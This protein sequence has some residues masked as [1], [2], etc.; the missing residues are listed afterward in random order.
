[1]VAGEC[2]TSSAFWR[3]DSLRMADACCSGESLRISAVGILR[4]TRWQHPADA[5]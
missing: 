2:G 3:R 1:M 5:L 4:I